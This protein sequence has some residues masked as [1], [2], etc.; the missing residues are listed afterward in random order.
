MADLTA[1]N[2]PQ[3]HDRLREIPYNYTS[4]SDR[5]IVIRL[6]GED[7]WLTLEE[8]R[9]ERVT[10]RSAR[11]LFEVLGD[12]WAV[13]RNP[14]LEDD[15]LDNPKRLA[16][17]VDAMKHRLSEIEKRRDGNDKVGILV[18][19]AR[20]AVDA[21]ANGFRDTAALRKQ[22]MKRMA[23]ITRRDNICFDGLARVSHVTDATDWRVEYPFVV[24]NPDTEEEMAPLVAACIELKLTIIP[25]GGGTGYTGGAVPL[26]PMSA[27]INTEKLDRHNG[28]EVRRIP[29]VDHEVATIQC[30]AG[31]VTRRVMEAAEE[32]GLVFAVD[33]T[34][35]DASC[36]GGNV[37]MNAGGKKAVLWGTALDNLVSWKMVDPDG[38]WMFVERLD[39][40][41]S[42]IH[43][44]PSASF[45]VSRYKPDGKTLIREEVLTIAGKDFR[46]VGLGKDV[47]DKFLAGLPGIQKEGTDGIITSARFLLHRLP[48]HTR[49]VCLEFFGEVSRAVPAIVE[50]KDYIDGL[51]GVQLAGLEHLDWRYVRAVGYATKAKSRGRPKMVLIADIVSDDENKLGQAAS[52]VVALANQ[53]SGE[54]FIAV[55]GEQRKK[56]WLDR[57]RTAAIAK[58]T[59][60]FKINEDV[61]IPLPRLGE[62]SDAIE[63]INIELSIHNKLELLDALTVFFTRGRLPMDISDASVSHEELIGD[64]RESALSQI[65]AVRQ[66]WQWLLDNLDLPFESYTEA[67]P[68]APL[69]RAVTA[70][71]APQSVYHS[72]RD[73][74]LR[75]SWRRELQAALEAL[76]CGRTDKPILDA[77]NALHGQV[78]KGRTWVALHMHAGDGNVHTNLP[79]NSDNYEM[80]QRAHH[81]VARI[82]QVARDLN[83]VISGEHGIGITKYEF[84]SREELAPFE[85]YKQRVDPNGHFNKGKLLPGAD[86]TNAYTP[87]FSLL[88]SESLILEQSGIGGISNMVKDCLRCGKCKPV[89]STHVPRANLLYSPRNKILATGLLT[90]AF[91]YEEQTRRG[92]S[93]KH[94]EELGDVADHC[95]VCH[96]CVNPCPVKIDFGDVSIA[97]RNFLRDEG[98]KKFN[99][100]TSLAM[101]FLTIKDPATIKLVRKTTIEWG[102]KAQRLGHKLGKSL[103]LIQN[104]LKAPPSSTGGKPPLKAQV[105][106][107]I[108]KPMPGNLPKKTA[109]ALLDVEDANIVPVIRN[110]QLQVAEQ[111]REAVFYFPGCGSERLFSQVGLATQAML[112]H[113]GTTTVLPPGYLC[114][115]Y[116]QT[117][118][119]FE[120]KGNKITT[121]NRVLFHRV[122]NTLNYLDIKT[123]IV[124]CGTCMD[125]LLKYQFEQI[126]PGCRLLD[127]H[128][129]LLEKGV[130]LEGVT[131][132]RYMYHEP[133]HTP[134][135]QYKGI[136]VANQLMG[137]KVDLNDR[138]CGESG[139]F[140]T[141]LPHIATQ[142]RFRKQE[143]L[144][145]GAARL[146]AESGAE[147]PVKVLTSCP[148]CLQGLHRY[149]DDAN[150]D[151]DYIVVEMAK[152][153]L[154]EN[155]MPEYVEKARTGGIERVLL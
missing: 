105:I 23:G 49:T 103:G 25:R 89:C 51:D 67:W 121:E 15:L 154:G 93:L 145:K 54:G 131:G 56:F 36:I 139:T 22:V 60:A 125:Q 50:I 84:L 126:F 79:V 95:T 37:A 29:G 94:F 20:Q 152:Y 71:D 151:A 18:A 35:A 48:A 55:T 12:I 62:Y 8:L 110:P 101:G 75:V 119:G 129:Y 5:E 66:R 57:A 96:R 58:H 86:L 142:V 76:F 98:Q 97:M 147:A 74:A 59:N 30:G 153:V 45:K 13:K 146:R 4:F 99:P 63:R 61:V 24:L 11:M 112:W 128:E 46:K 34:S 72:M 19:R 113:V 31:V 73:Y 16:M 42:K 6:L 70:A 150:M 80:L 137:S 33:P 127:I 135:K 118:A 40:N 114:C 132:T 77:V 38:N 81:A 143:E 109:R 138:C 68:E 27:V 2:L 148:S 87:S 104:T 141:S 44:A 64:R 17:L 65:A 43:D 1:A 3:Q 123:V 83:G 7:G 134:M 21:F 47:T 10:G 140:G 85:A 108:N 130:K 69:E 116:P 155:W 78:L 149:D 82:M 14:Y 32:K 100:M 53:R 92:V 106:H 90:E 117:S 9:R 28:V 124:S 102:G 41:L 52:H 88:G 26:T 115:G 120:D 111:D 39:H 122:A 144:E 133:C 136:D 107:F 91:L